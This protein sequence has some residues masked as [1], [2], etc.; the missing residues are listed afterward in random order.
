ME[1][2]M[3]H[4]RARRG[5]T[6]VELLVVIAIIAV[7]IG[8]LLPAV[9]RAREQANRT[10]CASNL[11]QIGTACYLYANDNKGY[12]PWRYFV[13][14]TPRYNGPGA[15]QTFGPDVGLATATLPG[16]GAALLVNQP[17]GSAVQKYL[18]TPDPFFCPGD[19]VRAPFRDKTTGWGPMTIPTL[20]SNFKSESY[21]QWYLPKIFYNRNTGAIQLTT[22]ENVNDRISVKGA[23][24]RMIWT[25]QYIPV[26][27][28]DSTITSLYPNFHTDM[29]KDPYR[30]GGLNAL[31][32][33]SHVKWINGRDIAD[34]GKRM[35]LNT[36]VS[37]YS[38]W[39]IRGC[40]ALN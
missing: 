27:P 11:R 10:K 37:Q 35:K 3:L 31:Y 29:G 23:T 1:I 16:Q 40:D 33:D 9:Q 15:T 8:I 25:D 20:T 19:N 5:F 17:Q 22:P 6:L 2:A 24:S 21:W 36:A 13:Y 38:N 14:A 12:I 18:P 32:L 4:A 34:Y 30:S 7:L 28:A 26:P 39:M